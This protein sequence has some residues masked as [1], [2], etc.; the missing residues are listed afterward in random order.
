MERKGA[1]RRRPDA[2]RARA[3]SDSFKVLE[4]TG[5]INAPDGE[6]KEGIVQTINQEVLQGTPIT[7]GR[8]GCAPMAM[9]AS[10]SPGTSAGQRQEPDRL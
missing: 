7:S 6:D 4:G 2:E 9:T 1:V 8:R 3:D 10:T 5:G